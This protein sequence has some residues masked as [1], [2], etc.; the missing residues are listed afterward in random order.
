LIETRGNAKRRG[1]VG[2]DGRFRI[3]SL[4]LLD[5][6]FDFSNGV[7][8][9]TDARAI[10]GPQGLL[11]ARDAIPDPVHNTAI[12]PYPFELASGVASITEQPL[13]DNP[14][15][16]VHRQR[17]CRVTPGNRI[18]IRTTLAVLTLAARR[19]HSGDHV[20]ERGQHRLAPEHLSSHLV[21]GDSCAKV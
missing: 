9:L 1:E 19:I 16:V 10:P 20:L 14:G 8:V 5:P 18:E 11:Q 6:T 2:R 12:A 21:D 15:I 3:L 7:D 17:R 13:E 4:G